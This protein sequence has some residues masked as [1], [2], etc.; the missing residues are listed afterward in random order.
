MSNQKQVSRYQ[1]LK[2]ME[3]ELENLDS[4]NE[5]LENADSQNGEE[6]D[7][8]ALKEENAKLKKTNQGLYEESQ[9]AKGFVRGSNGKWIKPAPKE[10][11]EKTTETKSEPLSL[12]DIRALQDVH[13]DDVDQITDYAKFKGITVAEA[14]KLPEMQAFFKIRTE[15]RATATAT[16]VGKGGGRTSKITGQTLLEKAY[17]T[18]ETPT[19]E[20]EIKALV[21][22]R[23]QEKLDRRKS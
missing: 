2:N 9:K 20:E 7:V 22:A 3:N 10:A 21:Q 11:Q 15:E 19:N 1:A 16:I 13:D 23:I 4:Q 17:E 6:V 12:K 8:E 14:K 18:G 5:E